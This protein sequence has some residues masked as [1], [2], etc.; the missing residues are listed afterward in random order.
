MKKNYLF[1]RIIKILASLMTM[2]FLISCSTSDGD[3]APGSALVPINTSCMPILVPGSDSGSGSFAFDD[4]GDILITSFQGIEI[5][6]R[7]TCTFST[8]TAN[9]ATSDLLSIVFDPGNGQIYTGADNGSI[10]G[11]DPGTGTPNMLVTLANDPNSLVIAPAGFGA[12]GGQL[13]AALPTGEVYAVNQSQVTPTPV[14]IGNA[15]IGASALIFGADGTLYIATGD[16]TVVTMTA[17]GVVANFAT[18]MNEV[19]GLAIDNAGGRLFIADAGSDELLQATIPGGVVSMLSA[20]NF[21]GGY[22]PS[23]IVFDGIG[24]IVMGLD[25]GGGTTMTAYVP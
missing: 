24:T 12:Y 5:L 17:A 1:I 11:V 15:G 9:V 18:G 2:L 20:A 14:L 21:D 19:D 25:A 23:P 6:A 7:T 8:V 16:A 13:I 3:D 4:Q 22:R 10:Y